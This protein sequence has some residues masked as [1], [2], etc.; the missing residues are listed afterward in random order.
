MTGG[1]SART[2][3][4]VVD[5]PVR[6]A[7]PDASFYSL[8]GLD[9]MR[10]WLRGQAPRVPL[11]HLTGIRPTQVGPGSVTETMPTSPALQT[12]DGNIEGLILL[13][14]T[15]EAAVMTTA[16]AAHE[17]RTGVF[18]VDSLRPGSVESGLFVAKARVLNSGPTF[19][20]AEVFLEDGLGRGV[21]HAT[22]TFVVRPIQPPPPSWRGALEPQEPPRY[23]TPDPYLR[24]MSASLFRS[25]EDVTALEFFRGIVSGVRAHSPVHQLLG[26]RILEVSEGCLCV[27]VPATEWLCGRTKQV[28]PGLIAYLANTGH[29]AVAMLMP[30]GHRL[31]IL[32]QTVSFLRAVAPDGKDLVAR[33]RVTHQGDE[34]LASH[35]EVSDGSGNTVAVGSQTSLFISRRPQSVRQPDR[36]LAT[37]LFTDIVGSTAE[38]ERLGDSRWQEMLDEHHRIVRKQLEVF[39]GRE[40][41]TTGDGFLVTFD[42]PGQAVQAARAIRDGLERLGLRIRAGLHTGECEVTGDDIAGIAVHIASRVQG[43]AAPGEILVSGTVRDLVTGSGL[44]FED[45]G[46]QPLKGIEGDWP[47]LALVD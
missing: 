18:S 36:L 2:L 30:S 33:G 21:A 28:S 24:T 7:F 39:R 6:G 11:S 13:Q 43:L 46:R 22:G 12:F 34:F 8:A 44:R 32:H 37:V 1:D 9:Q 3:R 16:P 14:D 38:A 15:L 20:L 42:S 4:R 35:V 23:A 40:V 47:I 31:G 19:T 10:A 41:K 45:R 29:G 25:D 27:T 26:F 5:E 17:V